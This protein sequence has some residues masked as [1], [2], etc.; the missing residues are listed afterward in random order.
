MP[1]P[2]QTEVNR[3]DPALAFVAARGREGAGFRVHFG[4]RAGRSC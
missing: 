1:D 3:M 2:E 4:G